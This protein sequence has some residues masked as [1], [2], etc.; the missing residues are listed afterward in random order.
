MPLPSLLL[1]LSVVIVWGLSFAAIKFGVDELPPLFLTALR[2]L[3]AALPAVFFVPKP[4]VAWRSIAGFGFILG[5]VK[6]SAMFLAIKAGL[7]TG[8]SSILIQT[9]AF[10]TIAFAALMFRERPTRIQLTGAA[11]AFAGVCLIAVSKATPVPLG[12]VLLVLFA[13]VC[14]GLA[15][16]V[17][18][19]AGRTDMLAFII[20]SSLIPPIPLFCLSLIFEGPGAIAHSVLTASW[21]A[22]A[23]TAYMIYGAT[24]FGFSAWNSLLSRH[25]T[26]S[27][28]PFGLLVPIVGM[29]VGGLLL[30]EAMPPELIAGGL[31]VL[32]GLSLT[33]FGERL[34]A[35]LRAAA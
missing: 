33:L 22:W 6:F 30:G 16:M 18:K 23:A 28:A 17:A 29:L 25:S 35:R 9:Q 8:L 7:P 3:L 11:V 32:A 13:A 1:A 24:L 26:A 10:F 15:N 20:W 2:F 14:W 19:A 12:T 34:I 31:I 27:V 5:V 4:A 21:R